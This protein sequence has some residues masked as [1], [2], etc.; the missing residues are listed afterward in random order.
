[1]LQWVNPKFR[2]TRKVG[3]QCPPLESTLHTE[4]ERPETVEENRAFCAAFQTLVDLRYQQRFVRRDY[5][6][7]LGTAQHRTAG[8]QPLAALH[9]QRHRLARHG[10][11]HAKPQGCTHPG[12]ICTIFGSFACRCLIANIG[13]RMP[14]PAATKS[15]SRSCSAPCFGRAVSNIVVHMHSAVGTE[16]TSISYCYQPRL[17][18]AIPTWG[19]A[20]LSER[21]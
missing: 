9:P 8:F 13:S 7:G 1:M 18:I 19:G 14:A 10:Y 2:R 12:T 4:N 16:V 11:A 21:P 20:H 15:Q 5:Y 17:G 3:I 6:H